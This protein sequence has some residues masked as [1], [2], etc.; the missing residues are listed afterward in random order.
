MFTNSFGDQRGIFYFSEGV[1]P[2][3]SYSESVFLSCVSLTL[4]LH[5]WLSQGVAF[6]ILL[7]GPF[8]L[9]HMV[10]FRW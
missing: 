10:S 5:G 4:P 1:F 7:A 8:N 6:C 2:L 3:L 9:I